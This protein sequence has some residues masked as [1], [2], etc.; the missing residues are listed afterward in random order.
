MTTGLVQ[1]RTESM[2]FL[3]LKI[4]E[5]KCQRTFSGLKFLRKCDFAERPGRWMTEPTT[6]SSNGL[7]F[8]NCFPERHS[9]DIP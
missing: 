8:K 9:L 5:L 3:K 6:N 7:Y 1:D 4:V 2:I